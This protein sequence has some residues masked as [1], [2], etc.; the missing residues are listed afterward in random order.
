MARLTLQFVRRAPIPWA[1]LGFLLIAAAVAID[2]LD[3]WHELRAA[4]VQG[5]EVLARLA[6]SSKLRQDELK[7]QSQATSGTAQL[8]RN[9]ERA[10]V[11]A[12]RYPWNAVLARVEQGG[13]D[14]VALLSMTHVKGTGTQLTVEALDVPSL[15]RFVE[16]MNAE[17]GDEEPVWYLASQV[18]EPQHSPPRIRGVILGK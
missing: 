16:K 5:E 3:V 10:V 13:A 4:Q 9:G 12:L 17:R 14:G 15:L 11:D 8:R 2:R 1:G 6:L 18:A 7:K